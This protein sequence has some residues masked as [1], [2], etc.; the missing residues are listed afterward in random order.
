M[1][2]FDLDQLLANAVHDYHARTM[3][4][5]KPAGAAA[6]R[7][8]ATRRRRAQLVAVSA[9]LRHGGNIDQEPPAQQHTVLQVLQFFFNFLDHRF[10]VHV[11]LQQ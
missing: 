3:P 8:T 11:A 9:A 1:P 10:V 5:I 4:Y 7:A 2:N 6:A